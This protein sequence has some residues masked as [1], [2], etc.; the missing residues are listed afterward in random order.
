MKGMVLALSLLVSLTSACGGGGSGGSAESGGSGGSGGTDGSGGTG[1][2]GGSGGSTPSFESASATPTTA[3]WGDPAA[4]FVVSG[5]KDLGS[6]S[7]SATLG[8]NPCSSVEVDAS[9]ATKLNVVCA[10]PAGGSTSAMPLRVLC[11]GSDITGGMTI[12]LSWPPAAG[13]P[14]FEAAAAVSTSATWGQHHASLTVDHGVNLPGH[15]LA[16]A[17]NGIPCGEVAVSSA[18]AS[19][20]DLTCTTP[21]GGSSSPAARVVITYNGADISHGGIE[22]TLP[23]CAPSAPAT[24]GVTL[25]QLCNAQEGSAA[26]TGDGTE[27]VW[28]SWLDDRVLLVAP[29]GAFIAASKLAFWG[30]SLAFSAGRWTATNAEALVG[31]SFST[32]SAGGTYVPYTSLRATSSASYG[33]GFDTYS[34]ANAAAVS[35]ASVVG[36]WSTSTSELSIAVDGAGSFTGTTTGSELGTCGVS[37]SLRPH[38]PSMQKNLFRMT[39]V[40]TGGGGCEI[41]QN[42]ELSGFAAIEFVNAGTSTAPEYKHMLVFVVRAPGQAYVS[43]GAIEQ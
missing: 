37:G 10:I 23:P 8:G 1:G 17:V 5:G 7:F 41:L 40:A 27:G 32:F 11:N 39:L 3:H 19:E 9:D 24:V 36:T 25:P 21:P 35:Q 13:E 28:R 29:D 34:L 22:V 20:L 38:E 18:S 4:R 12:T 30:G 2:A 6:N 31:V 16:A 42:T 14:S 15:D 43:G 26:A 33:F